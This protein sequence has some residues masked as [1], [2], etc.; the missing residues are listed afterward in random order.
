MYVPTTHFIQLLHMYM[1]I[2]VYVY[3]YMTDETAEKRAS[4]SRFPSIN[5]SHTTPHVVASHKT[6]TVYRNG[7]SHFP[8][9]TVIIGPMFRSFDYLL[10]WITVRVKSPFGAVRKLFLLPSGRVMTSLDDIQDGCAYVAA[11]QERLQR[12]PYSQ[13]VDYTTRQRT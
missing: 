2:H 10:D 8:G 1:F 13:I 3:I 9:R 6:I 7:D 5:R 4:Q 12:L 11:R